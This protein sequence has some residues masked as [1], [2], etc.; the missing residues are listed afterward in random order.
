ML[1][2]RSSR[3]LI[4]DRE[5]CCSVVWNFCFAL[6]LDIWYTRTVLTCCF[7]FFRNVVVVVDQQP[8]AL[9]IRVCPPCVNTSS[10]LFL[11]CTVS[12]S[13]SSVFFSAFATHRHRR[14]SNKQRWLQ[15]KKRVLYITTT[16][17][18]ATIQ[19]HYLNWYSIMCRYF[20]QHLILIHSVH[21]PVRFPL[22][23]FFGQQL[24]A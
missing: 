23:F 3:L 21:V 13:R 5:F 14:V 20:Y 8:N 22:C 19:N 2:V 15:K 24:Q 16:A 10:S 12:I 7:Y 6:S 1:Y 9:S 18:Q 4:L 11:F 17:Y